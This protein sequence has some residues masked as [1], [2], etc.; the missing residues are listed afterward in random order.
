MYRKTAIMLVCLMMPTGC[1]VGPDFKSPEPPQ[2]QTYTAVALHRTIAA[3]NAIG[4]DVQ[5]FKYDGN[6]PAQ[7]W[8]LFRS[9]ALNRLIRM[10]LNGSPTV[11][12]A[13]AAL[14]RAR[15]NMRAQSGTTWFPQ[16]N[17]GL[18]AGRRHTNNAAYG[19]FAGGATTFNLYSASA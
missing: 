1:A 10:G 13:Q 19:S 15:E 12:A 17:L 6:I 3:A 16:L 5:C 18:S 8:Q 4:G 9:E 2:T 14:R 11:A 7:W